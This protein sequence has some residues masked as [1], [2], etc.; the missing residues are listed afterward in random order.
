MTTQPFFL[1]GVYPAAITPFN[2]DNELDEGALERLIEHCIA[3]G[4]AGLVI[5]GTTGEYY[6]LREQER[7][8][9]FSAAYRHT[10][11]RISLIAGCNAGSTREVVDLALRAREIG[12]DAILLS[13]PH[14]SLPSQPEL[15]AHFMTVAREVGLPIVLYNFPARAGVDITL[16][17]LEQLRDIPEIIAIKEAS[18]D[19]SRFLT[20]QRTLGDDIAVSC[21]S[22][23]QAYDY[24]TWGAQSWIAGTANVLPREHVEVLA[25]IR[26]GD[27]DAARALHS[28]LLPWIQDMEAGSYNQKAKLGL[29]IVGIEVGEVRGPLAPLPLAEATRYENVLAAA[30]AAASDVSA[31]PIV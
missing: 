26:R 28:A 15:A 9:L 21:G 5:A 31:T 29:R 14:T 30:I 10:R 19:F 27:L 12:Y 3:G 2:E 17:T 6:A 23:D 11:E 24:F 8:K 16:E 18:G 13:V 4:V 25:A 1:D 7:V 22:D 20:M